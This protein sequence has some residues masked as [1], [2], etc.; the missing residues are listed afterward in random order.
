MAMRGFLRP[1][2]PSFS[3]SLICSYSSHYYSVAGEL[4]RQNVKPQ[5][6]DPLVPL[7]K[8]RRYQLH[9]RLRYS[10]VE[11][12]D[13]SLP[14]AIVEVRMVRVY[15]RRYSSSPGR[16]LEMSR[17]VY[18]IFSLETSAAPPCCRQ[19][20]GFQFSRHRK[21][22]VISGKL[23]LFSLF[24]RRCPMVIDFYISIPSL[25]IHLVRKAEVSSTLREL[26][27][28][29]YLFVFQ[30]LSGSKKNSSIGK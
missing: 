17:L 16:A 7:S 9:F 13:V 14:V 21:I 26:D 5:Q 23:P 4:D 6:Y 2:F 1:L 3:L 25:D 11:S 20:G 24:L 18:S 28:V 8:V 12:S 29:T 22:R 15:C 30:L 19:V 27:R 10:V